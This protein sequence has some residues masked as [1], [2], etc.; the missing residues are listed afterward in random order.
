MLLTFALLVGPAAAAQRF[1]ARLG[2]GMALS[3]ALAVG[4]GVGGVAMSWTTDWPASF[5]IATLS[6][7]VYVAAASV[8]R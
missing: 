2:W 3:A 5:W 7:G 4:E 6:A 8:N 1:S